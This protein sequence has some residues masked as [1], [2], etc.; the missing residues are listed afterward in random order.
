L[1]GS[2]EDGDNL[3]IVAGAISA[4]RVTMSLFDQEG[5][6]A[7]IATLPATRLIDQWDSRVAKVGEKVFAL[8]GLSGS[9]PGRLVFK[10][11]EPAFDLLTSIEGIEQAPYFAKRHWVAVAR[12]TPLPEAV[13]EEHIQESYALVV[14]K[15]TRKARAELGIE[16]ARFLREMET[17]ER[18]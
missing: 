7:F 9:D 6:D 1:T 16:A 15:L 5:F 2:S 13:I 8:L 10:C 18:A 14:S 17:E 4:V 12:S 11:P 3:V